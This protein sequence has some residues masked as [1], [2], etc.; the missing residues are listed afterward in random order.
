M[1]LFNTNFKRFLC[2][3][4]VLGIVSLTSS[5]N[6][7]IDTDKD[8]TMEELDK[9]SKDGDPNRKFTK[10]GVSRYN[11]DYTGETY[12]DGLEYIT[13]ADG[14]CAISRGTS[15]DYATNGYIYLPSYYISNGTT[16]TVT[17]IA[18]NAF[19]GVNF[20]NIAQW[21]TLLTTIGKQAFANNNQ[22]VT[23]I[24]PK[25]V[26]DSDSDYTND[27][28]QIFPGTFE[29]CSN[30]TYLYY[31]TNATYTK[32]WDHAFSG[33]T[34]LIYGED[35]KNYYEL[36][37]GLIEV[38]SSAFAYC[39]YLNRLLMPTTTKIIREN[40]FYGCT[41]VNLIHLP[42]SITTV[43][44]WAFRGIKSATIYMQDDA[45]PATY[46]TDW[47][48]IGNSTGSATD[49][50]IYIQIDY[51]YVDIGI[52]NNC[53]YMSKNDG[54]TTYSYIY[55]YNG[56][57]GA[58]TIP[59]TLGG[60]VVKGI[61]EKAFYGNTNI[62]SITT[63]TDLTFIE[64]DAFSGCTNM[65]A[66]T[67]NEGL[68]TIGQTAFYNNKKV[69]TLT[70][71]STVTTIGKWAFNNL[72][73]LKEL[74][75]AGAEDGTCSLTTIAEG[76]FKINDGNG[77]TNADGF[78]LKI[79]Y[80]LLD[81]SSSTYTTHIG[82]QAFNNCKFITTLTF[83]TA[84]EALSPTSSLTNIG[85]SCFNS[86]SNIT[87]INWGNWINELYNNVFSYCTKLPYLYIPLRIKKVNSNIAT[88]S[89]LSIYLEGTKTNYSATNYKLSTSAEGNGEGYNNAGFKA[90]VNGIYFGIGAETN[91]HSNTDQ[92]YYY[93]Y[94]RG[95]VDSYDAGGH[96]SGT[97][98][99][100]TTAHITISGYIKSTTYSNK[101]MKVNAT[102]TVDEGTFNVTE[103]GQAAFA[104]NS[105]M[106]KLELPNTIVTIGYSG[107]YGCSNLAQVVGYSGTTYNSNYVFPT[108]LGYIGQNGC[109]GTKLS[110]VVLP[111]T[112]DI[113]FPSG[114]KATTT[115]DNS[116][117]ARLNVFYNVSGCNGYSLG[118]AVNTNEVV[119]T[120]L[121]SYNS[122]F[123]INAS[124]NVTAGG[125]GQVLMCVPRT[126]T[127][128]KTISTCDITG[129]DM[130]KGD[131]ALTSLDLNYGLESMYGWAFN[132]C[133]NLATITLPSTI[134]Y[135]GNSI[136]NGCSGITNMKTRYANDENT[137][138]VVDNA[139]IVNFA[140][141]T[142]K[143]GSILYIGDS[144]FSG[145]SSLTGF[146]LPSDTT[147]L[148]VN[149]NSFAASN[150][151]I[152]VSESYDTF[153][154]MHKEGG[155]HAWTTSWNS[156]AN[157]TAYY[158]A[159]KPS[160]A[161]LDSRRY[162]YYDSNNLPAF[163]TK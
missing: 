69:T 39:K 161:L 109:M 24:L 133:V 113:Y 79:P 65:T 88:G 94:D 10:Y 62:T 146:I 80:S 42:S 25:L 91:I 100:P 151:Y 114:Y 95:T 37:T 36:P 48:R 136:F 5:C 34:T 156:G 68:L 126:L 49:S 125:N 14:T 129:M 132:P 159:T 128:L 145:C 78:E 107:L 81:T 115:P 117:N 153:Y 29:N 138:S 64:N 99:E 123:Y 56:D 18:N 35:S 122:C 90:D 61:Y 141:N 4:A 6:N 121:S 32:I 11:N 41:S 106:N 108:S 70:I 17:S 150:A 112:V 111:T 19:N 67:L 15:L 157:A 26:V 73:A 28:N 135:L 60:Y 104:G 33:C 16:Y 20:T 59:N 162:W 98:H 50:N 2:I 140:T 75:F 40:A 76:A 9:V 8:E 139:T 101:T 66:I 54:D 13:A 131:T 27:K 63:N 142:D 110:Y 3:L 87:T 120:Y 147:N 58:V 116:T 30:L 72:Y 118:T 51:G 97:T 158:S 149:A 103:I 7:N 92:G 86:C 137:G 44:K 160:D 152:Y 74:Y 89:K 155:T 53:L 71:P 127:S 83:V 57:G 21:P 143:T 163:W 96:V 77:A 38:C 52:E 119:G 105:Y 47:N 144:A 124:R 84:P 154:N 31:E 82:N 134:K 12:T 22:M 1:K 102:E 45:V 43:E 55:G 130:L 85:D 46:T 148:T 23:F 93:I